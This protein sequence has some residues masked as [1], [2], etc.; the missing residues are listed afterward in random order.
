MDLMLLRTFQRQIQLQCQAI[1]LAAHDL[2]GA[3]TTGDT[4]HAWIAIQN[5]LTAAANISKAL[6]GKGGRLKEE[7]A[8]LRESIQVDNASPLRLVVMRNH[9]EHY[10]E[11]LDEW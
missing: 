7:R 10:D 11:K 4:I 5:L 9:F 3:M 2:N 8:S 1:M 6:W